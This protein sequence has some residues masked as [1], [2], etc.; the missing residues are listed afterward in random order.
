MKTPFMVSCPKFLCC[1]IM[2]FGHLGIKK[3]KKFSEDQIK[4]MQCKKCWVALLAYILKELAKTN[5]P[6]VNIETTLKTSFVFF[7]FLLN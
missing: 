4:K 3:T 5:L 1:Y 7:S 6:I 2:Q